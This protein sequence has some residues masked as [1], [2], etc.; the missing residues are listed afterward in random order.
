MTKLIKI[1]EYIFLLLPLSYVIGPFALELINLFACSIFLF[2][3]FRNK[4]YK[5]FKNNFFLLFMCWYFYLLLTSLLS[6]NIFLSLESSLFYFRYILFALAL[7]HTLDHSKNNFLKNF[8]LSILF[9]FLF[10]QIDAYIQYFFGKN[11][12]G[13]EFNKFSQARLSGLFGTE[14]IL[15]SYISRTL[16]ILLSLIVFSFSKSN[17]FKFFSLA[18]LISSDV[19][20]FLAAE[21]S[22]FFYLIMTTI[23]L[24]ICLKS[25]KLLRI[26]SFIISIFIILF[27][28]ISSDTSKKRIIDKT[29][30]DLVQNNGKIAIF[31]V[32]HQ[33]IYE[34]AFKIFN[35]NKIIG[36]GPKMFRETCKITKYK[37]FSD[38]DGTVDGCQTHPHNTYVQLLT[39]TGIIGVIPV[40]CLFFYLILIFFKQFYFLYFKKKAYMSD[41]LILLYIAVF[42]SL[43]PFVPTGNFFNNYLNFFIFYPL[44]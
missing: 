23:L 42:I 16:P 11:L 2:V 34:T 17:K 33:V 30:D 25:F 37:S 1:K 7:W 43:W 28:T 14:W 15:G 13:Y 41:G 22:A 8:C 26:F 5:Y 10:V 44:V 12:L 4:D 24:I 21:R 39:E 18:I 38:D 6:N 32:Q 27:I 35:D 29:Y 3:I 31:S 9:V 36:I 40:L 19:L 20:I